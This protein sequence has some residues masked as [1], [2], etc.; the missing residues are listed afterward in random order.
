M[1]HIYP[2]INWKMPWNLWKWLGHVRFHKLALLVHFSTAWFYLLKKKHHLGLMF[3]MELA[4][5]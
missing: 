3:W 2:Y 4:R 1:T 5:A